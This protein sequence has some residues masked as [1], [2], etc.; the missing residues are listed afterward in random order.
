MPLWQPLSSGLL[1]LLT[2][3]MPIELNKWGVTNG[4]RNLL[5]DDVPLAVVLL[6]CGVRLRDMGLG[7]FVRGS[8]KTALLWLTIPIAGFAVLVLTRRASI[9][10]VALDWLSNLLQNGFTEE[11][12]WRGIIFGRIRVFLG[13]DWGL[14]VQALLFGAWHYGADMSFFHGKP[15]VVAAEMIAN[16]A[17]FGYA[18]G[19]LTLRTG[20]ILIGSA[21]H[22]LGDAMGDF[23]WLSNSTLF[24]L[25]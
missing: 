6:L 17:L 12:L 2:R 4:I 18:M 24:S 8:L 9:V 19:F 1:A 20:N 10:L 13:S 16:Q 3:H 7:R 22:F 5:F 23:Q 11:F 14:I 15:L 21:F 25:F